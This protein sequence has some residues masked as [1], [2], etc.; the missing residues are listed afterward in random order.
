MRKHRQVAAIALLAAA[1]L[2]PGCEGDTNIAGAGSK[3]GGNGGTTPGADVQGGSDGAATDDGS[4]GVVLTG[5]PAWRLVDLGE[6]ADWKD[7]TGYVSD[8]GTDMIAVCGSNGVVGV[9]DGKE[10]VWRNPGISASLN[11]VWA[12][13]D[14]TMIVVGDGGLIRH[15]DANSGGWTDA[16]DIGLYPNLPDF[17]A[18]GGSGRDDVYAGG[19]NGTL[20]YF[21]GVKWSEVK[22]L[23]RGG[24]SPADTSIA[25]IWVDADRTAWI[26]SGSTIIWGKG[27][28]WSRYTPE[29]SFK[30]EALHGATGGP[31]FGVG[32]SSKILRYQ[33]DAWSLDSAGIV[34]PVL[35]GVF[36]W[37]PDGAVAITRNKTQ[38]LLV[39]RM[40]DGVLGW[41]RVR[42]EDD[43]A[44]TNTG[45]GNDPINVT[46]LEL[47]KVWGSG[48]DD[49]T[50]LVNEPGGG[51][52]SP[53]LL[54]YR[55]LV[56]E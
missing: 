51:D 25:D 37:A 33:A 22:D 34:A 48:P 39:W 1:I 52:G 20:W 38:P 17:L 50:I 28:L 43:L 4:G 16:T 46:A 44:F 40:V 3:P 5:D 19:V 12:Q 6:S 35:P 45:K 29:Q 9:Y 13:D 54:Q 47:G 24:G 21:D 56:A 26:A 49:L 2:A 8:D 14:D 30:L 10:P 31:L 36:A 41:D 27:F 18:I 32:F 11:G 42:E 53:D 15:Y 55:R 7:L 23:D